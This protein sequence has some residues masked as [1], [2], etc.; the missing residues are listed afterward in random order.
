MLELRPYQKDSVDAVYKALRETDDNPCVEIPTAGGKSC[1]IAQ[2]S[3]DA[4]NLWN[5]RVMILAHVRE[6]LEQNA[7]KI[8]KLCPGIPV[9]VYCAGLGRRDTKQP[10]IVGGIQSV[11]DK[12]GLF[13]KRDLLIV[14]EAHLIKTGEGDEG[15]Y[16]RFFSDMKRLNPL[17]RL[18]GY[19]ATPFRL[20][21]GAICKP[22]NLLN[23]ICY[24]AEIKPLI[25]QGY[26]SPLTSKAGHS[27]I[28][29]HGLHTR[30]G[31]FVQE[32]VEEAMNGSLA[33][34][35]ACLDAVKQAEGRKT[36]I[37]FCS[38]VDHAHHVANKLHDLT[39]DETAVLTGDTPP[40][41]RETILRRFRGL[42]LHPDLFGVPE[43]PI[44]WLCNVSVCTTGLD[45]PNIDCV[46]LL[47]PTQ[48]AGL[49]VQM[50]GRGFR[51]SPETGKADCLVLDY[52]GNIERH[53][54]VDAV[55]IRE[56]GQGPKRDEPL[57]KECPEC[58][59]M[60][61]PAVMLC[62]KC[63]YEWPRPE[64]RGVDDHASRLGILSGDY[65]D[66]EIPVRGVSYAFHVKRDAKPGDLPTMRVTYSE[67]IVNQYSEWLCVQHTGFPRT[68]FCNW[69]KRRTGGGEP[70]NTV[71]EAVQLANEGGLLVP[72]TITVRH[73]AG[74]RYP[75]IVGYHFAP[76]P[77]PDCPD[78][79]LP[80]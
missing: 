72:E 63:G 28:N 76:T 53:G 48:S 26:L 49:F 60:V 38:S 22:E 20:D 10:I 41:E 68:K 14:D 2:V 5:G 8:A 73:V 11:Y 61:H 32:E 43:K 19:T 16:R 36:I 24:R 46:V 51:L 1:C 45:I 35:S 23:R 57:A 80:F 17:V 50:V 7:D 54:P 30:A 4:V 29:L 69:W 74:E 66:E 21:G 75:K 58:R 33:V 67:D 31:E 13:G 37:V 40:Q 3:T 34:M 71:A 39:K 27:S 25:A 64:R 44:R 52:G 65:E 15:R 79:E 18:I 9:G 62:P 6:L 59:E 70:P 78:D 42:D 12:A 47:R 55:H 77:A 56:P